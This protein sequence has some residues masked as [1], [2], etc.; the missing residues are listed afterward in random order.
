VTFQLPTSEQ[1]AGH[2]SPSWRG[3]LAKSD[4]KE[5]Q[6]EWQEMVLLPDLLMTSE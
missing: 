2:N 6:G 4:Q 5:K 1:A 3:N